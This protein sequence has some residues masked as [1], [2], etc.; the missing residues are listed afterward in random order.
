VFVASLYLLSNGWS[1]SD[2]LYNLIAKL[3][4][5]SCH[6]EALRKEPR[7]FCHQQMNIHILLGASTD[8][9]LWVLIGIN[10]LL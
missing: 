8:I 4:Q 9:L 7:I 5:L 1:V 2:I 10:K 6:Q 3:P